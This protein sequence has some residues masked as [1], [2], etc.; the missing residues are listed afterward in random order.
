MI[1]PHHEIGKSELFICPFFWQPYPDNRG[2]VFIYCVR[3]KII[4]IIVIISNS[5]NSVDIDTW[6][7]MTR[8]YVLFLRTRPPAGWCISTHGKTRHDNYGKEEFYSLSPCTL[9]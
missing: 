7:V 9:N 8:R 5:P 6:C 2:T 1:C 3:V 4:I